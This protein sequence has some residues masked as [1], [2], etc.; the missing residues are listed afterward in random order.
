MENFIFCAVLLVEGKSTVSYREGGKSYGTSYSISVYRVNINNFS[1]NIN[2][3]A[4][5][6]RL[7]TIKV[8]QKVRSIL[9]LLYVK[10]QLMEKR[11]LKIVNNFFKLI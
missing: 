8:C 5:Y 3:C 4:D 11:K 9:A 7:I 2:T 10:L 1:L 6:A